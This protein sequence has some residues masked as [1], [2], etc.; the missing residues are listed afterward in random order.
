MKAAFYRRFGPPDMIE[1]GDMPDPVPA[2]DEILIAVH[3]ASVGHG[4]WK[5]RSG[6]LQAHQPVQFPKVP[7]RDGAGTVIALGARATGFAIG[8]PVCFLA[9]STGQGGAA[10]LIACRPAVAARKPAALS[11]IDAVA[12]AQAGM[13]A[14]IPLVEVA[15]V[16]PGMAVLV[17]GGAGSIGGIG[18]QIA[19]A[20]GAEVTAT[21][22][23][24]NADY[25]RGLG[26]HHVV[27][28]DR[29]D[30]SARPARYD[31]VFDM[32]GGAVHDRSY[33]VLKPRALLVCIHGEPLVDRGA[34]FGVRME[35]AKISDSGDTLG[36]VLDFAAEGHIRPQ[37]AAVLPLARCAEAHRLIQSGGVTRG[38][39]VLDIAGE[40]SPNPR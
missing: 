25:V 31:V 37:I 38:R 5:V 21:C 22:R 33:R 16:A 30:F 19:R 23:A 10:E 27:A 18:V 11:F 1:Y 15:R 26:A 34:V 7:G 17:H 2:D 35:I 29:E 14:W 40:P 24:A 39:L 6:L 9:R 8:D 4:D 12:V 3:A 20:R 36:R 32:L 13:S 28:Y